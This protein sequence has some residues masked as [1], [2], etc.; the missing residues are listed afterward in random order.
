MATGNS[1]L[2]LLHYVYG[3]M[4]VVDNYKV[5]FSGTDLLILPDLGHHNTTTQSSVRII[6]VI[7]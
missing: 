7:L 2:T 1:Q 5:D 4:A 3:S 6:F